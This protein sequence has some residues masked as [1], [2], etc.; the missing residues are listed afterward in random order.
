[1]LTW[2]IIYRFIKTTY[3]SGPQPVRGSIARNT[4]IS[5]LPTISAD[6]IQAIADMDPSRRMR[7]SNSEQP[8]VLQLRIEEK[9]LQ[10]TYTDVMN[11]LDEA[12]LDVAGLYEHLPQLCDELQEQYHAGIIAC[13]ARQR[14]PVR[15]LLQHLRCER[16]LFEAYN[17]HRLGKAVNRYSKPVTLPAVTEKHF[18]V[19]GDDIEEDLESFP[20]RCEV[21]VRGFNALTEHLLPIYQNGDHLPANVMPLPATPKKS[22]AKITKYP[23]STKK[24]RATQNYDKLQGAPSPNLDFPVGNMSIAELAAFHPGAIKSWDVIDRYCGNGGS[25]A[26]FA[27]MINHFRVMPRGSIPNNSVYRMMK[28]GMQQRAKVEERYTDWTPGSHHQYHDK[29]RFDSA[30]ISVTGFRMASAGRNKLSAPPIPIKDLAIGVKTFP[31]GDDALDLTRAVQYCLAHPDEVWMYPTDYER[32][33]NQLPQD[34]RFAV[35]PAGPAPVQAGHHDRAVIGRY[36]SVKGVTGLRDTGGRKRGYRGHPLKKDLDNEESNVPDTDS[37][38]DSDVGIGFESLDLNNRKHNGIF[39]DSDDE[40]IDISSRKHSS[41]RTKAPN[42]S[43]SRTTASSRFRKDTSADEIDSA[44]DDDAFQGPKKIKEVKE[45]R[46][47]TRDNK[48]TKTYSLDV[49]DVIYNDS[50]DED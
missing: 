36:S 10:P 13:N 8:I 3:H 24:V 41:K 48:F 50:E 6:S 16:L 33:V 18:E 19:W 47:S 32:L 46:R 31:L 49:A 7:S 27:V 23:I 40:E 21:V 29:E 17:K 22:S 28:G 44:S 38:E 1:M 15:I 9:P 42:R 39:G 5:D 2:L 30:S 14:D 45:V 12:Q 43:F 4:L 20:L 34:L 26:S 37:E 11:M 35:Y 25:Q